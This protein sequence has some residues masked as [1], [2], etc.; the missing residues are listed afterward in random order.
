MEGSRSNAASRIAHSDFATRSCF[1]LFGV[2]ISE[3]QRHHMYANTGPAKFAKDTA[4]IL[5]GSKT[6]VERSY[7]RKLAPKDR[8][9]LGASAWK[10]LIP[11]KVSLILGA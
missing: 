11:E 8:K 4:Q 3:K 5:W 7:A 2:T 6:L 1:F 9:S 10:E